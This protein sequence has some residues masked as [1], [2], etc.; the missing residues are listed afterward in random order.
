[1][2]R[3]FSP[4]LS[5]KKKRQRATAINIAIGLRS[6]QLLLREFHCKNITGV[7]K[8]YKMDCMK[9]FIKGELNSVK[10]Q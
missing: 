10:E 9:L 1:M 4:T 5:I 7:G 3:K 2:K 6:P 8:Q